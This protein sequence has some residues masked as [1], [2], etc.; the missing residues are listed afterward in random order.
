MALNFLDYALSVGAGIAEKDM[1]D[2][3]E[4]RNANF[5]L[6]LEEFK[7]NKALITKLAE[8]RYAR[9]VNRYDKEFEKFDNLKQVYSQVANNELSAKAAAYKIASF[10]D[11]NW[12]NYTD[13]ERED[14]SRSYMNSF[15]Y[16]YKKYA[17]GDMIPEGKKV[18]DFVLDKNN[19]K[20]PVSY[21]IKHDKLKLVEPKIT[22]YFLDSSYFKD[23]APKL[24]DFKGKSIL[25]DQMRNLLN[26]E[27]SDGTK[28]GVDLTNYLAD[29]DNKK[30]TEISKII[31]TQEYTSTNVTGGGL[32]LSLSDRFISDDGTWEGLSTEV[33]GLWKEYVTSIPNGAKRTDISNVMQTLPLKDIEKMIITYQNG[34]PVTR[35]DG[36]NLFDSSQRLYQNVA[37]QLWKDIFLA[38]SQSPLKGNQLAF[39]N[40]NVKQI[41][42]TEWNNRTIA[43]DDNAM[44]GYYVI[45]LNVMGSGMKL[46]DFKFADGQAVKESDIRALISNLNIKDQSLSQARELID[47]SV[48]KF[49]SDKIP[50]ELKEQIN[51]G[52]GGNNNNNNNDAPKGT[53]D[54]SNLESTL[55]NMKI[56]V[57]NEE[58]KK[59]GDTIESIVKEINENNN[60]NYD[61]KAVEMLLALEN[62]PAKFLR[63]GS[64]QKGLNPEYTAWLESG[65]GDMWKN[66]IDYLKSIEPQKKMNPKQKRPNEDWSEWN[67]NYNSYIKTYE[68]FLKIK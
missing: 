50:T 34:S 10:E 43:V 18:G 4:E 64:K 40:A 1:A 51:D 5:N 59:S 20:I 9:D 60:T 45:P 17:E 22:D 61:A 14:I 67:S 48:Y 37:A 62:P 26:K 24:E 49:L 28:E 29:L 65:Q 23:K 13:D 58:F 55:N 21:T 15:D 46:S 6:A 25:T 57:N 39:T 32:G 68:K 12:K 41:Y 11:P 19:E 2:M 3:K 44:K 53:N 56:I 54:F 16:N 66:T 47:A 7:D 33:R 42:E 8:N 31:G 38:T 30:G 35:P 36:Q 52:E 27:D 63:Q